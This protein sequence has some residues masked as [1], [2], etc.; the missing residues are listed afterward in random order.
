MSD[1]LFI[2]GLIYTV[3][4]LNKLIMRAD[5]ITLGLAEA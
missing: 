1:L 4:F 5:R 3:L 2:P